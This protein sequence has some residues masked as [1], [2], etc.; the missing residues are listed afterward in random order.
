MAFEAFGM[1]GVV[2]YLTLYYLRQIATNISFPQ[3][4]R[5]YSN[6]SLDKKSVLKGSTPALSQLE[7]C[8]TQSNANIHAWQLT[9]V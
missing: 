6:H 2:G 1:V 5:E 7:A 4:I 8:K 3:A 9:S